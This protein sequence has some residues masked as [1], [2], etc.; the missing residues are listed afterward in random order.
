MGVVARTGENASEAH[1]PVTVAALEGRDKYT[2][3]TNGS[4][5]CVDSPSASA[6]E[7]SASKIGRPLEGNVVEFTLPAKSTSLET[8]SNAPGGDSVG[9]VKLNVTTDCEACEN[10]AFTARGASFMLEFV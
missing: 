5:R 6:N 8:I 4:L 1:R 10:V 9:T 7:A 3:S 2:N